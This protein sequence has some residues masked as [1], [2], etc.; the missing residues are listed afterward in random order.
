MPRELIT[1]QVGQCGNQ[2]AMRFWDLALQEHARYNKSAIYDEPLSSFFRNVDTRYA[3][4]VDIPVGKQISNLRARSVVIDMEEGVINNILRSDLGEL[5]DSRQLISDVS[6]AGNNWAHGHY[7]YGAKYHDEIIEKVRYNVEHCDSLQSFFLMH[8][9]GGGTGSG[10]GTYTLS[11]LADYFPEVFRF[12]TVVFPEDDVVTGPYNSVLA[13][14]VLSEFA[15]CV[16]PVDNQALIGILQMIEESKR[17]GKSGIKNDLAE[18][19][20]K[21]EAFAKM[22]NII[23]HML[24]NL[25]CSMRFEGM[26]NVDLNEITM[27]LVPFPKMPYLVSSISP[28]Y[29]ILDVKMEPRRLDQVFSDVIDKDFQLLKVDPKH[30]TYLACGLI[31]RGDAKISD[32]HRNINRIKSDMN[33]IHWNQEGYKIGLF[34]M[35]YSL[36]C[37]SNNSCITTTFAN[38]RQKFM[39]LYKRKANTHHYT[40]FME[41]SRFDQALESLDDVMGKYTEL[42]VSKGKAS[43]IKPVI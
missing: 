16:L 14:S 8:S 31:L 3:E 36:L 2:V 28:L 21:K 39:R 42:N 33:M 11:I 32:I 43:R 37:L 12:S 25:T 38:L 7:E 10:V 18:P 22:N 34:G 27:N 9:M 24:N 15:D 35:P 6:G 5:F 13:M 19:S 23:A 4:P 26:L 40:E 41:I 17:K 29:S 30:S 1:I 20:D